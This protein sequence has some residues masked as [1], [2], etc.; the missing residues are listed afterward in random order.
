MNTRQHRVSVG[1]CPDC[2]KNTPVQGIQKCQECREKTSIYHRQM[3]IAG[4]TTH[5]RRRAANICLRCGVVS[6]SDGTQFCKECRHRRNSVLKASGYDRRRRLQSYDLD[7]ERFDDMFEDQNGKCVI[8]SFIF[9]DDSKSGAPCIDHDHVTGNVR[10]L[11]C[12]PCNRT[13]GHAKEDTSR[14]LNAALYL[15]RFKDAR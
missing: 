1:L 14:L 5:D 2:G 12:G 3:R 13:L 11:L 9:H 6:A 15:E 4:K 8:C 10:A 7:Q